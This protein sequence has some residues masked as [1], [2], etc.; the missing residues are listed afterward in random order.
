MAEALEVLR[1]NG[2]ELK[3][4]GNT[5]RR[6]GDHAHA[7]A[8]YKRTLEIN[9]RD[10]MANRRLREALDALASE[11]EPTPNEANQSLSP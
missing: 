6:L 3:D 8:E 7:A 5:Y 1:S 10:G 2:G 9:P 4:L 11:S